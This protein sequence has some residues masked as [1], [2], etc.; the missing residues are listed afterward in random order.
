MTEKGR[1][2]NIE[3]NLR[4]CLLC[5]MKNLSF[6]EDEYHLFFECETYEM[7]RENHWRVNRSLDLFH[8]LMASKNKQYILSIARFLV[9]AFDMRNEIIH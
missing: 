3:R 9:K 1:H 4:F 5:Q 6:I 2:L 8:R 7:L